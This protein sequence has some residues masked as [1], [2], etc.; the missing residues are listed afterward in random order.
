MRKQ[1][2]FGIYCGN[3]WPSV[4]S[5]RPYFFEYRGDIWLHD[6]DTDEAM[7]VIEGADGTE[8]LHY[9]EGRV[10][11]RLQMWASPKLGVLLIYSKLGAPGGFAFTSKGDYSKLGFYTQTLRGDIRPA[12]LYIPFED[13]WKAVKEFI[14]TDGALPKSIEWISNKDLTPDTFPDPIPER[15]GGPK[16]KFI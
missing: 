8:K 2:D 16:L 13:A 5:V 10:D 14:E 9:L 7:L 1:M 15:L 3:G 6:S 12:W 4:E 11:I